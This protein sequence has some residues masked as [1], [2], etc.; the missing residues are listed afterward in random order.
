M[1]DASVQPKPRNRHWPWYGVS[2]LVVLALLLLIPRTRQAQQIASPADNG[3]P[4]TPKQEVTLACPGRIE[5]VSETVKVG[6]GIDGLLKAVLVREGEQ[7]RAGQEIALIDRADLEAER[8]AALAAAESAR[9]TRA[10][11]L[12]GSRTEERSVAASQTTAAEARLTQARQSFARTEKLFQSGDIS[13][14]TREQV[15]RDLR[16]AEA[17]MAAATDQEKLVNAEP[18]PEELAKIEAEI[19]GV[20]ERVRTLTEQLK[21]CSL[22]APIS[23]SVLRIH[24]KP[25]EMVS[26]VYPQPILSIGDTSVWRVRAEVDERD[27][28]RIRLQQSVLVQSEAFA[29]TSL[30]G[31]VAELGATMGRKQVRTGDP[32]EKSD[33][34]ILEVLIN[35]APSESKFLV[36]GLRVTVQFLDSSVLQTKPKK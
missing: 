18:L 6:A 4:A 13:A 17:T 19:K 29:G 26:T 14:E 2:L 28:T 24:L 33:R 15:A 36:V 34:D 1:N 20:Q 16:V 30:Q 23:G 8:Q 7:V 27:L 12:R 22:K 5:A 25:G 35:L 21:K 11:L 10:R 32:A 9:Q 3:A 31:T